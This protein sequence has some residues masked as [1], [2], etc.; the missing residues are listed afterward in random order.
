MPKAGQPQ[1]PSFL[2]ENPASAT[3]AAAADKNAKLSK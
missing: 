3:L 2:Y 1:Y